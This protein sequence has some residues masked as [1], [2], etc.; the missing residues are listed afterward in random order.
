MQNVPYPVARR[1]PERPSHH[2]ST[3][4]LLATEQ[5]VKVTVSREAAEW[6]MAPL[7]E[8]HSQNALLAQVAAGKKAHQ[9]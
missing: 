6:P 4:N 7:Q 3:R 5:M 2:E 9:K 8:S 1:R